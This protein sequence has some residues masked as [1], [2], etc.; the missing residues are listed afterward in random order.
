MTDSAIECEDRLSN[1]CTDF[2]A[3]RRFELCLRR[4]LRDVPAGEWVSLR[5]FAGCEF[6]STLLVTWSR[7][8]E[9]IVVI[10]FSARSSAW[11]MRAEYN[12]ARCGIS[13]GDTVPCDDG[14]IG[15]NGFALIRDEEDPPR[16]ALN[17]TLTDS[18]RPTA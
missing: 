13:E 1:L 17:T 6:P 2:V 16:S 18:Q 3:L 5:V 12:T 9:A 15:M 10:S 14:G 8:D 4:L 11:L 7:L